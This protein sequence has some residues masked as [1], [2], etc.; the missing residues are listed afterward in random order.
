MSDCAFLARLGIDLHNFDLSLAGQE[1]RDPRITNAVVIDP[2][3]VSTLTEKS[4]AEIDIPML[5]I[6][7]GDDA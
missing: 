1:L 7:L 6:N 2:G 3:I 5:V 4:L